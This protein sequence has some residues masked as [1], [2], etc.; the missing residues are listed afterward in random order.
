MTG[1]QVIAIAAALLMAY[2]SY[3][4]FRRRELRGVE[5]AVWMAVWAAL[6]LVSLFPDRLRAVIVP[7]AVARLLDL[8]VIGGVLFLG[9]VVF[10]LNRALRRFENRLE[11][12]VQQRALAAARDGAGEAEGGAEVGAA[13]G[14]EEPGDRSAAQELA[15][16]QARGQQQ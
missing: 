11:A 10:N 1:I 14:A 3:S 5:F 8:V 9:V 12:L 15:L 16:G 4:G 6:A 7:L 13:Q 2:A